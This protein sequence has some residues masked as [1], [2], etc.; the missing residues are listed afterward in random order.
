[1]TNNAISPAGKTYLFVHGAWH[2]AWCWDKVIPLVQAKG[3]TAIAIELPGHGQDIERTSEVSLKDYVNAVMKT[4]NE[5][6][7]EVLLVGHSMA[8]MVIS[9]AAEK[10]GSKKVSAL[11]YLDAFLPRN[12]ESLF[13]LVEATLKQLS[14]NSRKPN[15]VENL[16]TAEDHQTN[17]VNPE[18][19]AQI[20]YHDCSEADKKFALTR[21]S[22]EPIAPLATPVQLTEEVYGV[23]PKYFI[24]CTESQDMDKTFLSTHV[25]CEKV[26]TL[27]SSHS[28]FFSMP[29]KL[30]E[31][32][33][34]ISLSIPIFSV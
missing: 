20:F 19:A 9:Q 27:H 32:I 7:G 26:Y 15:L 1:M 21:L 18:L 5:Q 25:P 14:P 13:A 23:I 8:G 30:A 31:I 4:A 6:E 3:H 11:I 17:W 10:L 34:E 12:G 24:L 33:D 22:K 16:I 28:P 2:G 29:E